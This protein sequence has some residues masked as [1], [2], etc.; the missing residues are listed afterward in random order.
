MLRHWISFGILHLSYFYFVIVEDSNN[1]V[2]PGWYILNN[3]DVTISKTT[4]AIAAEALYADHILLNI[5]YLNYGGPFKLK[6]Y[7]L[8]K[9][10]GHS[11]APFIRY[12]FMQRR[13]LPIVPQ[14][15]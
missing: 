9:P 1:N 3:G 14:L 10:P 13:Q 4:T 2:L 5:N 7:V 15:L 8:P 6:A 11:M 12:L